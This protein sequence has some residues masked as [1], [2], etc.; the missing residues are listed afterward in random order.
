MSLP[1]KINLTWQGMATMFLWRIHVIASRM[2]ALALFASVY[3]HYIAIVCGVHWIL[4]FLWIVSMRTSFCAN[5]LE[6]LGY[7]GVLGVMYIFCYFNPVDSP[8][9]FRYLT[10]YIFSIC[11]NTLLLCLWYFRV[12]SSFAL[13][14]FRLHVLALHYVLFA[15]GLT[16]MCLY[17]LLFHPTRSI[18]VCRKLNYSQ[19]SIDQQEARRVEGYKP[20]MNS[21]LWTTQGRVLH[22]RPAVPTPTL[23]TASSEANL[24][25]SLIRIKSTS[26]PECASLA[27]N[28]TVLFDDNISK[29]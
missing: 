24:V 29:L 19:Q 18:E 11:E 4:M 8:T 26:Q 9:R 2:M 7:N 23:R 3:R 1:N 14:P 6:E 5:R 25:R 22:P 15:M 21:G 16:F 10:F 13:Y 20:Q 17:Y 27:T 28:S 12:N